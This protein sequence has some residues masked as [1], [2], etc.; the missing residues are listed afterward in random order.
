MYLKTKL[1]LQKVHCYEGFTTSETR[2]TLIVLKVAQQS[3][4]TPIWQSTYFLFS[5]RSID[6][7]WRLSVVSVKMLITWQHSYVSQHVSFYFSNRLI[8]IRFRSS[9]VSVRM[10][11]TWYICNTFM[12]HTWF[13]HDAFIRSLN[14]ND[15]TVKQFLL[16]CCKLIE[17]I[18]W[19]ENCMT[20]A[21]EIKLHQR[22]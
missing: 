14:E 22:E 13:I 5:N 16:C 9:I 18:N 12:I 15:S 1:Y 10:L 3:F 21:M 17:R 8:D 4:H 2:K 19:I 6:I 7:R 20:Q 11:N